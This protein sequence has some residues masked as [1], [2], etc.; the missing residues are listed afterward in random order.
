[1]EGNMKQ[2]IS[3]IAVCM[4]VASVVCAVSAFAQEYPTK[5]V[6]VIVP[7]TPGSPTDVFARIICEKLSELWGQ[8][9]VIE[10]RPG[11]GGTLGAGVVAKSAPDG[12]TF[13]IHSSSYAVNP[14]LYANLPY[15]PQKGFVGVAPIAR[16]PFLL[17]VS[18]SAGL[19]SV[20]ELIVAA[21]AKPGQLKFGSAGVGTAVHLV[22]EKFKLAAGIDVVHVPYAGT[23]EADADVMAGR[24]SYCFPPAATPLKDIRE[25]KLLA[26]G[27]TSARRSD[28]L[29]EVPTMA[30]AGTPLEDA[31]WWGIW[32]PAATP[33]LVI[34]KVAK[35]VG[36]AL[37]APDL[38]EKLTMLGA[39]PMSMTPAEFA[40]FVAAETESAAGVVKGAGIKPQ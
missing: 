17:V 36:R 15:D 38:R 29:P 1:M 35:D 25:G 14:A 32:A 26:I 12:Y 21:K 3:I 28:F 34:D 40:R 30:E 37:A 33:A 18:P 39:Q 24:I 11:A 19:K 4:V 16:Q 5:P 10:H 23:V 8:P 13:L 9:V 6:R 22:A 7:Y 27:V 2:I 31:V 20:S